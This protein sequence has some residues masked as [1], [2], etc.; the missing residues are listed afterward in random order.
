MVTLMDVARAAG[1][2]KMTVSNALRGKSNVSEA[3]RARIIRTA[4]RLNYRTNL[5]ARALSSGRNDIIEFIVQ[6]LDSPF[7]SELAKE[8]SRAADRQGMQTLIRQT[9]YSAET[10]KSALSTSNSLFCDALVLATPK[11]SGDEAQRLAEQR[12]IVLIDDCA[13]HPQLP[14]VNTPNYEGAYQAVTHLLDRGARRPALFGAHP[15][16]PRGDLPRTVGGLRTAGALQ[17]MRDA[18]LD[19]NDAILV[20]FDW[21]YDNARRAVHELVGGSG[22]NAG[23]DAAP[24]EPPFD[25]VFGMSDVAALGAIRGLA[26]LGLRVP[27]DVKVIGFDGTTYGSIATP[28]LSTIDIDMPAMANLI[29]DR[30]MGQLHARRDAE[31]AKAAVEETGNGNPGTA[32]G[33][34]RTATAT[35]E[36]VAPGDTSNG[37]SN[38][39][40]VNGVPIGITPTS[41]AAIDTAAIHAA[42]TGTDPTDTNPTE[43]SVDVAP[44]TLRVREST[45]ASAR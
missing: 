16:T 35:D 39:T 5:A 28:S 1:V 31:A 25:A 3:T 36:D 17:A 33:T 12:P 23:E 9:L 20:P 43:A 22:A 11:I 4:Q 7:Y 38:G 6:D 24:D 45:A 37:A 34:P 42:A 27:R 41:A 44:F 14:T 26:D 30:V 8:V 32:P 29:V 2:S 21:T 13:E 15:T 10:E 18:G 19:P 40:S